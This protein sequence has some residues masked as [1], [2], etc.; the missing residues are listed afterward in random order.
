[1]SFWVEECGECHEVQ[2]IEDLVRCDNCEM[3]LCKD[4]RHEHECPTGAADATAPTQD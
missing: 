4:C 1:M 2:D 3:A